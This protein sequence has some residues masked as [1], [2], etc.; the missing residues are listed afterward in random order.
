MCVKVKQL[1]HA[2]ACA[3]RII[4]DESQCFYDRLGRSLLGMNHFEDRSR[5]DRSGIGE[6]SNQSLGLIPF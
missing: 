4:M 2:L 6:R 5:A 3:V 1:L